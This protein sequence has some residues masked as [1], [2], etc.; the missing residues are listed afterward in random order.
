MIIDQRI[1]DGADEFADVQNSVHGSGE[2][3]W[4][5]VEGIMVEGKTQEQRETVN[6]HP[7]GSPGD[8][9]FL[10]DWS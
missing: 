4:E 6:R 9:E 2:R 10:P 5:G 1:E 7:H 8:A 3:R